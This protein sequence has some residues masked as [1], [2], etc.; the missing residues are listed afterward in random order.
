MI[1]T[2]QMSKVVK[3]MCLFSE[4]NFVDLNLDDASILMD[5]YIDSKVKKPTD[6]SEET[7]KEV[8]R[9]NMINSVFDFREQQKVKDQ[10]KADKIK[11][12]KKVEDYNLEKMK[13]ASP[14]F[15]DKIVDETKLEGN[16]IPYLNL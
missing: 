5:G 3:I 1:K 4:K 12:N 15:N 9:Q 11:L 16:T 7:R 13:Q 8:T 2:E 6:S 14:F 10:I